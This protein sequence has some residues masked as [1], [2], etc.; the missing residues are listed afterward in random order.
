MDVAPLELTQEVYNRVVEK[1]LNFGNLLSSKLLRFLMSARQPLPIRLLL[2]L[3]GLAIHTC[4][5]ALI[6][7]AALG[8]MPVTTLPL[9]V[10]MVSGLTLGTLTFALNVIFFLIEVVLLRSRF[11]PILFLQIPSVLVFSAMIDLWVY[12][13]L[14]LPVPNVWVGFGY[15]LIANVLAAVG[16]LLQIKSDTLM[17]PVEGAVLALAMVTKRSFASLKI[18]NDVTCV[19]LAALVSW[20]FLDHY[21]A[22][23]TGTLVSAFMVGYVVKLLKPYVL[24]EDANA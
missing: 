11:R 7:H 10:S 1:R 8:T 3:I 9:A 12:C 24:N 13:L 19:T 6:T 20:V 2:L 22:I 5:I 18:T 23:G 21:D 17:Q 14:P 15:S 16:I 4:G